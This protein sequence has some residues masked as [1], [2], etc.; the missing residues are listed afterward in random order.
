MTDC[1][2]SR[3]SKESIVDGARTRKG[4]AELHTSPIERLKKSDAA[5]GDIGPP[6]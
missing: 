3:A 1:L 4:C 2:A 5:S 6:T